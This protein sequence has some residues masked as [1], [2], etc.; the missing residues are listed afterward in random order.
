[1]RR[2]SLPSEASRVLSDSVSI[3]CSVGS[4]VYRPMLCSSS[5]TLVQCCIGEMSRSGSWSRWHLSSCPH[6]CVTH[7]IITSRLVITT[8]T[9]LYASARPTSRNNATDFVTRA[10]FSSRRIRYNTVWSVLCECNEHVHDRQCCTLDTI[11]E[12]GDESRS[13]NN[14]RDDG[15]QIPTKSIFRHYHFNVSMSLCL[16][17][18]FELIKKFS[19]AACRRSPMLLSSAVA[20]SL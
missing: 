4:S 9:S 15:G 10:S 11:V 7:I 8:I 18:C 2:R 16:L 13:W 12:R 20:R 5:G 19:R 17:L 1:M 14:H 6:H 3:C